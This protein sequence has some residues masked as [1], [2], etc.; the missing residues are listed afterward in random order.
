MVKS[1]WEAAL[2]TGYAHEAFED[3]HTQQQRIQQQFYQPP[4]Q[5]LSPA[6]LSSAPPSANIRSQYETPKPL[7][8]PASFMKQQQSQQ[9]Q[10][11][12]PQPAYQPPPQQ[13]QPI[14]VPPKPQ[15]QVRKF[16]SKVLAG[17]L[18]LKLF[19]CLLFPLCLA[20]IVCESRRQRLWDVIW[21]TSRT[22]PRAGM[23]PR[24]ICEP[25]SLIVV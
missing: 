24:P 8:T 16:Y 11:Q 17:Y 14:Y 3:T 19:P 22:W 5:I 13:Q 1:P 7:E 9:Y 4:A 6:P 23:H 15:Q 2:E 18:K 20:R 21:R 12:A 10:Y 25:V